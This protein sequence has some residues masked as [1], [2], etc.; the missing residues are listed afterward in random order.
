[1]K[2]IAVLRRKAHVAA[3]IALVVRR[4]YREQGC[5]AAARYGMG[6]IRGV[7]HELLGKPPKPRKANVVDEQF[8]TDTARSVKLHG[9]DIV[10]PN[11][12][13]G[14]YYRATDL[15]VVSEALETSARTPRGLHVH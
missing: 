15:R 5:L 9:L 10:G 6:V 11:Y 1:M 2:A 8:G 12:G 3:S 7:L 13:H 14:V 4:E